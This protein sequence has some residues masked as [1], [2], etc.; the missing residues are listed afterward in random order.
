MNGQFFPAD[1]FYVPGAR[2]GRAFFEN[3]GLVQFIHRMSGYL[4]FAFG[5]VV[6]LRGR[7]SAYPATRR[8]FNLVMAMLVRAGGDRHRHGADGGAVHVAHHPSG[9]RGDPVGA[10]PARPLPQP[11]PRRGVDPEGNGMTRL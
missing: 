7:R 8:A 9:G 2:S 4:L 10:D 5:V 1:A 6:W 11:I 3:P